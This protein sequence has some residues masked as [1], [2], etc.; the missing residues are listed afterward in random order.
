M[1]WDD[2]NHWIAGLFYF[3]REDRRILV[4]KRSGLGLG[5]TLNFA[6]PVAWLILTVPVIIAVVVALSR[7]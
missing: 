4:P 5:R 6:Q 3:N 7:H 2:D 1:N